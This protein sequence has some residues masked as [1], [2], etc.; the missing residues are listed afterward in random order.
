MEGARWG[1][2]DAFLRGGERGG[3]RAGDAHALLLDVLRGLEYLHRRER[4]LHRR[5]GA[6]IPAAQWEGRSDV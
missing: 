3:F 2:L 5:Y 6:R 4:L 1:P